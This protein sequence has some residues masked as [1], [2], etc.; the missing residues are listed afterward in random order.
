MNE[1]LDELQKIDSEKIRRAIEFQ[2]PI[3]IVTY[4][5]PKNMDIY[6]R[7][8]MSEF[9]KACHQSHM[10]EYL[11][12]CLGELL[13]NS[14]KANTKRVYF[15]E[16]GLDINDPVQYERGMET[17]KMDTFENLNYYLDLQRKKGLYIKFILQIRSNSSV[18]IEIRNNSL[19]TAIEEQRIKEKFDRVKQYTSVEEVMAS[20][21]DQSEGAGLGIIII[22]LMLQK[23]GLSRDEYKVFTEGNDTVTRITLPCDNSIQ[24]ELNG[25]YVTFAKQITR[26]PVLDENYSELQ[27]IIA[28]GCNQKELLEFF[29]KDAMLTYLL[30]TYAVNEKKTECKL[31]QAIKN[32][33]KDD[34]LKLFPEQNENIILVNNEPYKNALKNARCAG[35]AAYCV[36]KNK[37]NASVDLEEVYLT[38]LM[39]NLSRLFIFGMDDE[40]KRQLRKLIA[41]IE[42]RV[43]LKDLYSS[44]TNYIVF[45]SNL[46]KVKNFP[47]EMSEAVLTADT[48]DFSQELDEK[49]LKSYISVADIL[50]YYQCG[51]IEYYQINKYI[52]QFLNV[53]SE[54][55]LKDI[56]TKVNDVA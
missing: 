45:S 23:I 22:I 9:L 31:T 30:L 13:T 44:E 33:T 27:A 36:V 18:R 55:Q 26:F 52:L 39:T 12:F 14:K 8:T 40:Q 5:L 51:L 47:E 1:E 46:L 53:T 20:V 4:T 10:I 49:D 37:N 34:Y 43:N 11:S 50:S 42:V 54:E 48:W 6:I 3:E 41:E 7:N 16:K 38:A 21:M 25:A 15:S 35:V 19:L 56:M 28:A 17:F 29:K 24:V 2:V 32:L